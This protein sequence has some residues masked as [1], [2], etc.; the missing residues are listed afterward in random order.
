MGQN[1]SFTDSFQHQPIVSPLSTSIYLPST[2]GPIS[3]THISKPSL[4]QDEV[5]CTVHTITADLPTVPSNKLHY[6]Q[7]Q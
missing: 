3:I 5:I 2:L 1:R 4:P 6:C 7:C